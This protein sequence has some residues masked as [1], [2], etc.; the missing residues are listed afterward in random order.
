MRVLILNGN[1]TPSRFDIYLQALA[2]GL[3]DKENEIEL[4][5]LREKRIN[6]CTG[7]WA[8]WWRTPGYCAHQD[9]MRALYPSMVSA[10]IVLWA[11]PL[12][13]GGISAL[14]KKTQ[15]RFIPLMHPYIEIVSGECHHRFRYEHNADIALLIEPATGDTEED[16]AITSQFFE[17]FSHNTRTKIRFACTTAKP[18][19]EIVNETL[20]C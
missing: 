4:V 7:C 5:T 16:I 10:D 18:I 14:L 2:S 9:D 1:P 8:C 6:Y 19:E 12:V 17:R 20:S 15:D 13:M 3:Q 11:S